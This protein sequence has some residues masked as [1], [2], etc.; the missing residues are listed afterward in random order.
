MAK[1]KQGGGMSTFK[2]GHW[3]KTEAPVKTANGK[4][5]T[6]MGN[7]QELKQNADALASYAKA[8]KTKY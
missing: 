6:E 5:A 2:Q 4:Y 1:G 8:K 3:E 7:P